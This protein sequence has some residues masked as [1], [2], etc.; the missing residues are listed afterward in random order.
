MAT[1][2]TLYPNKPQADLVPVFR[3]LPADLETPVSVFLKLG[4]TPPCFLLESVERGEQLGRYSF[5][6]T[7]PYL[8]V[9]TSQG[10]GI[11]RHKQEVSKVI[12]GM[13]PKGPD[14]LHLVQSNYWAVA[15]LMSLKN[16]LED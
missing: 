14:P 4:K 9:Q 8:T 11:I 6:G 16:L 15:L 13:P 5:F 1:L 10:E 3:E 7:N 12:L 2:D